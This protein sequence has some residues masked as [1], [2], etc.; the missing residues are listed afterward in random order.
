MKQG[1]RQSAL[2]GCLRKA[3][4]LGQGLQVRFSSRVSPVRASLLNCAPRPDLRS[5]GVVDHGAVFLLLL[6]VL[7]NVIDILC[8]FF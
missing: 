3:A 2:C 8:H 4:C 6:T 7:L 5:L 1:R